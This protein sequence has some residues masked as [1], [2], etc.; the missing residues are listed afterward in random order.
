MDYRNR[1]TKTLNR[2]V[3]R[4]VAVLLAAGGT[5][6][7]YVVAAGLLSGHVTAL[8]RRI[9]DPISLSSDPFWFLVTL[10]GW[11]I[12]GVFLLRLAL[13]GWREGEPA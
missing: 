5:G 7:L 8:S 3:S 6:S 13:R 1:N 4:V 12:L 9:K 10:L 11:S 2:V